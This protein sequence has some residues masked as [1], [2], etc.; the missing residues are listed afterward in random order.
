MVQD[1]KRCQLVEKLGVHFEQKDKI[2][3]VAARILSYIILNGKKGTTFEEL[4]EKLCASKSTISTHLTNLQGA[5]KVSYF[6]K[7]GDRKKYFIL[8]PGTIVHSIDEMV[9]LWS[10]HKELHSEIKEFKHNINELPETLEAE[11][12]DLDFH[13]DYIEFLEKTIASVSLL[14]EKIINKNK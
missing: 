2:A 12:F 13:D 5:N 7:T 8:D 1:K 3:P 6:T 4:V 10:T 9:S 11:R 14:K